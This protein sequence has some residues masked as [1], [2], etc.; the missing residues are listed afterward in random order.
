MKNFVLHE[1]TEYDGIR[2]GD[3]EAENSIQA[4]RNC[5]EANDPSRGTRRGN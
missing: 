4:V 2:C 1:L 5:V 3:Y